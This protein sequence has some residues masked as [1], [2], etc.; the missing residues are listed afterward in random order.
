[1]FQMAFGHTAVDV[2][3]GIVLLDGEYHVVVGNGF[4]VMS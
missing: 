2:G 3:D 4:I 1:M